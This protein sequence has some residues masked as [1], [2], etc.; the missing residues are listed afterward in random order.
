MIIKKG[1]DVHTIYRKVRKS[2]DYGT[3]DISEVSSVIINQYQSIDIDRLNRTF[4]I[5]I[6]SNVVYDINCKDAEAT[7][8]PLIKSWLRDEQINN[9]IT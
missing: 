8:K 5:V 1:C 3:F 4:T 7:I 2:N 6:N 9:V